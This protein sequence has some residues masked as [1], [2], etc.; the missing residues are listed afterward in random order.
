MSDFGHPTTSL[1]RI[2]VGGP[3]KNRK[4][5]RFSAQLSHRVS[6]YC[7][8][9]ASVDNRGLDTSNRWAFFNPIAAAYSMRA[10]PQISATTRSPFCVEWIGIK[11]L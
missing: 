7:G 9:P 6:A 8:L 4:I 11:F 5:R 3:T 1:G 2:L 10:G